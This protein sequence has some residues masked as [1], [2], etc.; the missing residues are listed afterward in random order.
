ML[1]SKTALGKSLVACL[2]LNQ[3][4][5]SRKRQWA[6]WLKFTVKCTAAAVGVSRPPPPPYP[7][8]C[9]KKSLVKGGLGLSRLLLGRTHNKCSL[10]DYS[11]GSSKLGIYFYTLSPQCKFSC[12]HLSVI[13]HLWVAKMASDTSLKGIGWFFFQSFGQNFTLLH[14]KKEYQSLGTQF[15][16]NLTIFGLM[17]KCTF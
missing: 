11:L 15:T 12:Y 9:E 16:N 2:N 7:Q 17:R 8:S 13:W 1:T 4:G 14:P 10:P 5:W 6:G 3:C